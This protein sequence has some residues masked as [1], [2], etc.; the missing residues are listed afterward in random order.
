MKKKEKKEYLPIED[1]WKRYDNRY[2]GVLKVAEEARRLFE[3]TQE[4]DS[5][6]ISKAIQK[7]M[8]GKLKK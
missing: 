3:I 8:N 5:E 7:L 4:R 2:K 1:I 6:F